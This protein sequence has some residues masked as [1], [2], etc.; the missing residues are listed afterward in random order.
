MDFASPVELIR[1]LLRLSDRH[2]LG[3]LDGL[4]LANFAPAF[5]DWLLE[6]GVLVESAPMREADGLPV[7]VVGE[8]LIAF[9]VNGHEQ[10]MPV[11]PEALRRFE[12]DV[13]AL[14][15]MIRRAG[16]LSGPPIEPLS[17]RLLFLGTHKASG[18]WR[19]VCLARLLRDDN[20]LDTILTLRGRTG[21]GEIILMTPATRRLRPDI[22]R[23]IALEDVAL[24]AI[25]EIVS[26]APDDPFALRIPLAHSPTDES[27]ARLI[28]DTV[29]H[30]VA[31]DGADVGL[32]V[33]EFNLLLPLANEAAS[34]GGI[35]DN[36]TLYQA[37]QGTAGDGDNFANDEQVIKS[38]S[39]L[40]SAL[41]T[42]AGLSGGAR[43]GLVIN[44]RKV[45]YRLGLERHEI[46]VR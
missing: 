37:I 42:A 1:L 24:V 26:T 22:Q 15:K 21:H 41:A 12:I 34:D 25:S 44:K 2:P 8:E 40:R 4:D 17:H 5:V 31:F 20:V 45:G 35:V 19:P 36:D 11:D 32:A 38:A 43:S 46:I 23:R 28:V 7:Q 33:R 27:S 30:T 9:S 10:A 13:L 18:R 16:T 39:L 3:A 14:C 29:G 6:M